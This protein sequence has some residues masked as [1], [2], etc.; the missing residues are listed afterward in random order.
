MGSECSNTDSGPWYQIYPD[1][2]LS[3][4][5][6]VCRATLLCLHSKFVVYASVNVCWLVCF[7]VVVRRGCSTM[8][9]YT[10]ISEISAA[11]VS[12]D[13]N[14]EKA[15]IESASEKGVIHPFGAG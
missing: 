7:F 9:E 6:D 1:T 12:D 11:K 14:L 10:V 8:S 15:R 2:I 3:T 4:G 5:K 13:A